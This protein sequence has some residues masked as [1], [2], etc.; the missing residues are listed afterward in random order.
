MRIQAMPNKLPPLPALQAF[1]AA[2]RHENFAAAAQELNLSQSAVSHRVRGLEHHLGYPLF[3]RLPR[4]LRL[5]EAAKA[6]L[7]SV[8]RAFEDIMSATSGVFG[9][10]G[11]K[12]IHLR[13]PVSYT[14][15]WLAP[16]VTQFTEDFPGI[17]INLS[18]SIWVDRLAVGGTDIELRLGRGQWP[19]YDALPLFHDAL[20]PVCSF[21]T[22]RSLGTHVSAETLAARSLIHVMG[23]EDQ[24]SKFFAQ[25]GIERASSHSDI[26]VDSSVAAAELALGSDRIALMQDRLAARVQTRGQ[27]IALPHLRVL[28]IEAMYML[29][30]ISPEPRKSSALLFETWLREKVTTE[31]SVFEQSIAPA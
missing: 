25:S 29:T 21:D 14:A 30:P 28:P 8:R 22:A 7:P 19:G 16:L 5:T 31:Q 10:R 9:H 27:L 6:Y 12:M 18:S 20:V 2:A 23:P 3:E 13:A 26:G 11:D 24:W 15:L 1:E 4:G 17:R